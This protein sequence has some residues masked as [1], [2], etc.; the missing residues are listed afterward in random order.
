MHLTPRRDTHLAKALQ[1]LGRTNECLRVIQRL[2]NMEMVRARGRSAGHGSSS[3][4][5]GWDHKFFV[6]G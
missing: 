2:Q 3:V 6:S 4:D 5:Q 1:D